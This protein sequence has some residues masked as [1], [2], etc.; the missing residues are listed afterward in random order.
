MILYDEMEQVLLV[1]EDILPLPDDVRMWENWGKVTVKDQDG[2]EQAVGQHVMV[3]GHKEAI[4]AWLSQYDGV[5]LIKSGTYP[6]SKEF[7]FTKI[8]EDGDGL[9]K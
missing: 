3:R 5:W 8:E 7:V 1:T 2:Y 4:A 6:M 9:S